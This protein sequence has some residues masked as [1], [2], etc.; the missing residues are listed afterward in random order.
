MSGSGARIDY[1]AEWLVAEAAGRSH[2]SRLL[3][4]VRQAR[5]IADMDVVELGS[6]IGNNLRGFLPG[7][8]VL[9]VEG[10]GEAVEESRR[11]GIE[12]LQHDLGAPLPLADASA[13]CVL[14]IDVLEHLVRPEFC[15][16]EAH[17]LLRD[18]GLLVVNVPNHFDVR[19]RLRILRG[20]GIDSQGYFP[21]SS[22]WE[23]PHLRFFQHR[24]IGQLLSE[25]GFQ[26]ESDES[27]QVSSL[28]GSALLGQLGLGPLLRT[29]G[30]SFPDLFCPGFFLVSRKAPGAS[31]TEPRSP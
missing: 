16:S 15:L 11:R 19:G 2:V 21:E 28:P 27:S 14:C 18:G 30:R 13:D 4:G 1:Q 10:L 7:N 8:R 23:Y 12:A 29:L 6:G 3:D 5:R 25:C 17:R 9:G 20:S 26:V 24:S 22:H 31:P